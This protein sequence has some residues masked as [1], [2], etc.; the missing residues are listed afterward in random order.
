MISVQKVGVAGAGSMGTGIAQVAAIAGC[1]VFLFDTNKEAI[2]KSIKGINDLCEKLFAKGKLSREQVEDI[3]SRV[4]PAYEV[5]TLKGCDLFIEA[6]IENLEI[7]S[8]LLKNVEPFLADDAIIATNTS[9]LSV[10]AI[11]AACKIQERVIGLHFFNPATLMPLVEVIPAIQSNEKLVG[12]C[13]NLMT[14][15]GKVPVVAKDT[16]GFIVNRVARPFYGESLRILE[17]GI[18]DVATIDWALKTM[19]GFKMGPF[20]LMD[21]IGNDINYTVT[22]TVWTQMYFDARYRPSLIQKKM[23]EAGRL[24]RKSGR[25]YYE[26]GEAAIVPAPQENL[27]LGEY[28]FTRVISMLINEAVDAMYLKIASRDE[29]DLAMTKG[30]NYPKGLL[31]WADEI[32]I[33]VILSTLDGLHKEYG[34]DRYRASIFMRKMAIDNLKFYK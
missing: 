1:E 28:I 6:I 31:K 8:S 14:Q 21:L 32:G 3:K 18:A 30:V 19:G 27:E 5:E 2:D 20:E 17:E 15:W 13:V 4:N 16:P 9:S 24:G 26:Y 11:A 10:T 25:G 12:D 23:K 34:E 22:E 29:L 7:K 33:K